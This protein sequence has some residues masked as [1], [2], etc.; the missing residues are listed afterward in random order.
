MQ[1]STLFPIDFFETFINKQL[2]ISIIIVII[3]IKLITMGYR[4][5]NQC[6]NVKAKIGVM[7]L[8]KENLQ[9]VQMEKGVKIWEQKETPSD[10][11]MWV[12]STSAITTSL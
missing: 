1:H 10:A 11:V 2:L 8:L 6:Q 12:K 4:G 3:T 5:G 7:I 9:R